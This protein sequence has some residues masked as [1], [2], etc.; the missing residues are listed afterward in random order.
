[1]EKKCKHCGLTKD[2]VKEKQFFDCQVSTGGHE[3]YETPASTFSTGGSTD[4]LTLADVER[5][6]SSLKGKYE[7]PL[8]IPDHI[9]QK[10]C[11]EFF[12]KHFEKSEGN[13][14]I[15]KYFGLPIYENTSVPEREFQIR[16]ASGYVLA[17]YKI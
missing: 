6:C 10:G 13:C 17:R 16:N 4:V 15:G 12:E 8:T 2:E 1:M 11:R 3:W 7:P 9:A 14:V 5:L